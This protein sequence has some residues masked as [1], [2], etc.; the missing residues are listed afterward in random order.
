MEQS[1][2][3]YAGDLNLKTA[4]LALL[5][6]LILC[7]RYWEFL[8]GAPFWFIG[9]NCFSHFVDS[10]LGLRFTVHVGNVAS[11][12]L[13]F[14][15]LVLS[16][17]FFRFCLSLLNKEKRSLQGAL[18]NCFQVCLFDF[19]RPCGRSFCLAEHVDHAR[20]YHSHV[21]YR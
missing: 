9:Y 3:K 14:L 2:P 15:L 12:G 1:L 21:V 4:L 18:E 7:M 8:L 20:G 19:G 11:I 5:G 16:W 6:Y 17:A 13:V 10:P